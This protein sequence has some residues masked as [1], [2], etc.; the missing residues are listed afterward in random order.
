M[1]SAHVENVADEGNSHWSRASAN[2]LEKGSAGGKQ[3]DEGENIL[4]G[5][6]TDFRS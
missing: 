6:D 1:A 3:E 4:I 2:P 5:K